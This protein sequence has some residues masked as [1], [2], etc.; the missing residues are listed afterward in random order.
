M[1]K[2]IRTV[3]I[4][5]LFATTLQ[6]CQKESVFPT[7]TNF[8]EKNG[9]YVL[10]YSV[11]GEFST[12]WIENEAAM[13]EFMKRM[14]ILVN[15]GHQVEI[16]NERRTDNAMSPKDVVTFST[17]SEEEAKQW[18]QMMIDKGYSVQIKKENGVY[19]CTAVK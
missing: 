3:A 14:F 6:G 4:I 10:S 7:Q 16:R 17:R 11:D 9:M 15:N 12:E 19:N 8:E 5:A 13:S 2:V 18:S 1:K